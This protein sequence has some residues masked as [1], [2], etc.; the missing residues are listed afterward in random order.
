[1]SSIFQARFHALIAFS[2]VIADAIVSCVSNQTRVCTC[3]R[4]VKPSTN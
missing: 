4:F 2:R 1:M 3:Y